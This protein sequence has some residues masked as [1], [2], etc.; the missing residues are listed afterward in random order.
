M[1][2]TGVSA[3]KAS[4]DSPLLSPLSFWT[5]AVEVYVAHSLLVTPTVQDKLCPQKQAVCLPG[6]HSLPPNVLFLSRQKPFAGCFGAV[7]GNYHG[8]FFHSQI[9]MASGR[10]KLCPSVS[11]HSPPLHLRARTGTSPHGRSGK[12]KFHES[13]VGVRA[14]HFLPSPERV[15]RPILSS[16]TLRDG[17]NTLTPRNPAPSTA[18]ELRP[19]PPLPSFNLLLSL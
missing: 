10:A 16:H 1:W 15:I 8:Y 6:F 12:R 13:K 19:Q 18:L 7:S 17:A 2:G 5:G 11:P 3:D 14:P 4:L 9:S